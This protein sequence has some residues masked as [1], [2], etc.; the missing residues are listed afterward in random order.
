MRIVFLGTPEFAVTSLQKLIDS[1][2]KVVAVITQPDKKRGR[3]NKMIPSPVKKVALEYQL[4]VWQP[5][6]LKKDQSTL[7]LLE[8]TQADAFVVVAY[9]QI[10]SPQ[11]LA[12]PKFGCINV[13]GSI[14]PEYRG[15]APIQWSIYNGDKETGIT[16][17]LMDEGMDTGGMLLKATTPIN[18]LDNAYHISTKLAQ[19]GA[20]LLIETLAKLENKS[21]SPTPQNDNLAT[22]A[23]LINKEDYHIDWSKSALEIH[24]QARAFYPNC[25]TTFRDQS[26]KIIATFPLGELTH[27]KLPP[28]L[29]K[30][31]NKINSIESFP[32]SEKVGEIIK[33]IKNFGFIVQTGAGL[34]L[35]L[36]LQLAGKKAQ[37]AWNFC[38][39]LRLTEGELLS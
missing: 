28:E 16:T 26:L 25:V 20:D 15:A 31:P 32:K 1:N 19:Q 30:L 33:I 35:I 4:T 3:G 39:G 18:L 36:H 14:L 21:I 17:M 29:S 24:N 6:R 5:K 10:L 12:M 11:I 22:Y 9:G 2:H 13:H 8:K 38:N 27:I 34:L 23:R 37:S 7:E